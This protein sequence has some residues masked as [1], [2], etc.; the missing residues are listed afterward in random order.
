MACFSTTGML[1]WN[2]EQKMDKSLPEVIEFLLLH[3]RCHTWT[4]VLVY[5]GCYIQIRMNC[6]KNYGYGP[7]TFLLHYQYV[8][9]YIYALIYKHKHAHAHAV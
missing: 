1:F 3:K 2:A 7:H 4:L 8:Y 6:A 5:Q 9:I